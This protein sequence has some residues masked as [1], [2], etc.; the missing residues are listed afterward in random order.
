M[1]S[2]SGQGAEIHCTLIL[3]LVGRRVLMQL[4]DD[5]PGIYYPGEWGYFGGTVEPGETVLAGA[6]RELEEEIGYRPAA[7]QPLDARYILDHQRWI[8]LHSFT[9]PLTCPLEALVLGEGMDFDLVSAAEFHGGTKLSRRFGRPYPIQRSTHVRAVFDLALRRA[10]AM[11]G[12]A[13][14]TEG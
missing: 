9:C 8:T 7:L 4:R 10:E 13:V 6:F 11:P 14:P 5:I 3:P 1:A 12:Q 2:G